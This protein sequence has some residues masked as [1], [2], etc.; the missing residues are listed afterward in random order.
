MRADLGIPNGV[1]LIAYSGRIAREKSLDTLVRA[2]SMLVQQKSDAHM[3]L[4]GGGPWEAECRRLAEA[5]HVSHRV[6]ITGYLAREAV[7][8]WLAEVDVYCFPSL[9]D[10]QGV[11]VLEA[12]AM[13]CP[14][15]A[16]QSSA[17][18]D[19]IRS[20]IDGMIVEPTA[21]AF[22][23]G[24]ARLLGDSALRS[25]LAGQARQRA[26]EF[27]SDRMARRLVGVYERLLG[28]FA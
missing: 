21:E 27:S 8:N 11:V 1:P 19:V 12:M 25:R 3:V 24:I 4:I 2:F 5:E 14:P 7:F 6:H 9:T 22:A 17:V 15:V 16:A 23:D 10:T 18:E 26:E 28:L 13:G 20:E